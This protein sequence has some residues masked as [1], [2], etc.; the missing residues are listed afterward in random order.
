MSPFL[1]LC[2]FLPSHQTFA[3]S[4]S[5]WIRTRRIDPLGF[6]LLAGVLCSG[7]VVLLFG[8]ILCSCRSG[9][10]IGP[11]C[12]LSIVFGVQQATAVFTTKDHRVLPLHALQSW[13]MWILN[14]KPAAISACCSSQAATFH[15][16]FKLFEGNQQRDQ[17]SPFFRFLFSPV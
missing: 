12:C 17:Q 15:C 7:I 3:S 4:T 8:G 1:C 16:P 9:V 13:K 5:A 14:I 2:T 11:L 10:V 6:V